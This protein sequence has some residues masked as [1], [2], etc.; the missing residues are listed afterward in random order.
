MT[1]PP[2]HSQ[3]WNL[4][5][6][7]TL[8][9]RSREEA[10]YWQHSSCGVLCLKMAAEG[11]TGRSGLPT[12]RLI[13][14]GVRTHAYTHQEGWSHHGLARMAGAFGVT[15][16]ALEPLHA[17]DIK[18]YLDTGGF[19]IVSIAWG[20]EPKRTWKDRLFFWKKRGGHLALVVG[21]DDA[22]FLV[23]HTSVVPEYNWENRH[24]PYVA[25]QNAYTG[26]GVV[27]YA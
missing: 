3:V 18:R 8:G 26:R 16:V 21:Y 23:H 13:G 6:W 14:Y 5:Q 4:D 9:F 10:E 22:G 1:P 25:F 15:G 7:E 2:F 17:E 24:V 20:F 19:S 11:L 27:V 12:A